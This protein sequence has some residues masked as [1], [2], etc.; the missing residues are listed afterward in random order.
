MSMKTNYRQEVYR[1]TDFMDRAKEECRFSDRLY[2][3]MLSYQ[4]RYHD[5]KRKP[6]KENERVGDLNLELSR[7]YNLIWTAVMGLNDKSR[8]KKKED[9]QE[10]NL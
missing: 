6:L 5:R 3:I 7:L 4:E 9:K 10:V 1:D 2:E 8:S